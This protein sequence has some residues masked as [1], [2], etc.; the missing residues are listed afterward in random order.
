MASFTVTIDEYNNQPPSSV[1]DGSE[2][3]GYGETLVYTRAM[4]T[5]NTVPPYADP[6]GDAALELKVTSLP[7]EGEL[8]YNGA[9]IS[10]NAII[11]FSDIDLGLFTYVPDNNNQSAYNTTFDFEISDAG[12]GIFVG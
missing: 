8:Q 1:G 7:A 11:P 12:S 4:F 2:S 9:G 10:V 5:T 6:E 3:T